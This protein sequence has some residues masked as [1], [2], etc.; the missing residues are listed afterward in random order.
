M[1][2]IR[3]TLL[4]AIAT[5]IVLLAYY[6][7]QHLVDNEPFLNLPPPPPPPPQGK[8]PILQFFLLLF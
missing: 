7:S 1:I 2:G 3:D 4:V 6:L 8:Q 5:S